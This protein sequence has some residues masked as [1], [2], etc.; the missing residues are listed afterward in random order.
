MSFKLNAKEEAINF[1]GPW[2]R[3]RRSD[4]Q[5][6]LVSAAAVESSESFILNR[7]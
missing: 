7:L 1:P 2:H 4:L 6:Y 3:S 5:K